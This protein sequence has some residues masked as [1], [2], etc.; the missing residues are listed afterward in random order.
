M[1]TSTFLFLAIKQFRATVQFLCAQ[2][3]SF[4]P[5]QSSWNLFNIRKCLKEEIQFQPENCTH[6]GEQVISYLINYWR[7]ISLPNGCHLL[8]YWN[9]N[10]ERHQWTVR[11]RVCVC[12]F[13]ITKTKNKTWKCEG[14]VCTAVVVSFTLNFSLIIFFYCLLMVQY[15]SCR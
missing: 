2:Y 15:Q 6:P 7:L 5:H 1:P 4:L 3:V 11:E 13:N 9:W 14:T 12:V 8:Q 10:S